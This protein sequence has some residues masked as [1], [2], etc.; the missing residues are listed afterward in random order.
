M[1]SGVPRQPRPF[2]HAHALWQD[3]PRGGRGTTARAKR[4][5]T[6]AEAEKGP[7]VTYDP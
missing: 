6:G 4:E 3:L 1:V 7:Y 2:D 5:E